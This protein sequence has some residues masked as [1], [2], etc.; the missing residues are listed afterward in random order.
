MFGGLAQDTGLGWRQ[1]FGLISR[2][3]DEVTKGV[4]EGP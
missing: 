2:E 3:H 4:W 1:A